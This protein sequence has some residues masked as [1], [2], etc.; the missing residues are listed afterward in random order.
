M[1]TWP[2][3]LQV[4]QVTGLWPLAAPLPPQVSHS[5]S[6]ATSISTEWPNTAWLRSI[7]SSYL[8]S[9]PRKTCERPPPRRPPPKMSPN[10]SPNISPKA[11]AP[12]VAAPAALARGVDARMAVLVVDGALV[13]LAENFVSLFGFLEFLFRVLVT[14][15]AIRVIFHRKTTVGLLDVGLGRGARQI[16]HLV[17]IAFRHSR[18]W[19]TLRT[20]PARSV[21]P[22]S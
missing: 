10:I 14:R 11:S 13:R 2:T 4:S 12:G 16:E 15:I 6:L 19:R 5:M 7:S 18:P 20:S 1:R 3:P 9:A 21:Q 22:F 17:V 8:R